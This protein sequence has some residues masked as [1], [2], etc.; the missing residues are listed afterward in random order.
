MGE[1]AF[2][3]QVEYEGASDRTPYSGG[4]YFAR[5]ENDVA[6]RQHHRTAQ[7]VQVSHRLERAREQPCGKG[8]F[9]QKLRHGEQV[10]MVVESGS[11]RLQACQI[12]GEPQLLAQ[13]A[14]DLPVARPVRGPA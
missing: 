2:I 10:R 1:N 3:G 5:L 8:V 11:K 6:V 7:S 4:L 13:S 12:I 9:Q 14:E